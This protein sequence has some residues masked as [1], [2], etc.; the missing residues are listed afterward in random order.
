MF[1]RLV[2]WIVLISS[3][4]GLA[5]TGWWTIYAAPNSAENIQN[6]LQLQAENVLS[7]DGHDWAAVT[8]EGQH[9]RVSGQ[10]PNIEAVDELIASFSGGRLFLGPITRITS[11]IA[12]APPIS[13]YVFEGEDKKGKLILRGHVPSRAIKDEIL[14]EA[15]ALY[16]GN[17]DDQ[18]AIGTG[19]PLG[20]WKEAASASLQVLAGMSDGQFKLV[21]SDIFLS[22][23]SET[24]QTELEILS[25]YVAPRGQY[26]L[27]A[28]IRGP[29]FWEA[30]LENEMLVLK[31]TVSRE[32]QKTNLLTTAQTHFSG[33]VKDEMQIIAGA[34]EGWVET[35]NS[36]L[37]QFAAFQSGKLRFSPEEN[38]FTVEGLASGSVQE[39]LQKDMVE[40]AYPVSFDIGTVE[41]DL[42]ELGFLDFDNT[43]KA[44]CQD[45]FNAIM[46]AEAIR[47]E[48]SKATISRNS[49]LTL[50]KIVTVANRCQDFLIE[51]HGHTDSAGSRETNI[52]LSKARA[53]SVVAYMI[54]RGI[55]AQ[56]LD[57]VGFGP[58]IPIA[59]NE[60]TS[61]RAANRRIE[62]K[63][64]EE[65]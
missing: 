44:A 18:L 21:D 28:D 53:A 11:D 6:I 41:A 25:A 13:P 39:Y 27:Q 48:T 35:A 47:F 8:M 12:S 56:R 54:A 63:I 62:F 36:L 52:V 30:R 37:P 33:P 26:R 16:P 57:A 42:T 3:L 4:I 20:P 29:A 45:G 64:V 58:D 9:A 46:S 49:G 2:D 17:V 65:G 43:P 24:G 38:R 40:G 31:G 7:E 55:S 5:L 19:Q 22:G 10:S 59:D 23:Q 60:T 32:A 15:E 50:D 61:G 14:K 51:V 34:T 1:G